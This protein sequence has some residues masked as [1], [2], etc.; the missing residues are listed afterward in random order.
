MVTRIS[1][2]DTGDSH[3][4]SQAAGPYWLAESIKVGT[5]QLRLLVIPEG[6]QSMRRRP[7]FW[8]CHETCSFGSSATA[9]LSLGL[10]TR[11][12]ALIA[13]H[14]QVLA[15]RKEATFF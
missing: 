14:K 13:A 5:D 9:A 10:V 11:H 8:C 12:A 1:V 15:M 7:H 3:K 2:N 6:V 4:Y